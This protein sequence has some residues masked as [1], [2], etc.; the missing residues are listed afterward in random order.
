MTTEDT[1]PPC[2]KG[3]RVYAKCPFKR[4]GYWPTSRKKSDCVKEVC[5]DCG[6]T[7]FVWGSKQPMK[8]QTQKV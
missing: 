2:F 4:A 6:L 1:R 3:E 5:E 7:R 8:P